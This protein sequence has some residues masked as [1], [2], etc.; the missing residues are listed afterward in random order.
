M[1]VGI[2]STA[3][4]LIS[5]GGRFI[6]D[7]LHEKLVEHG[8][9]AE[10][11]YLP[12]VEYQDQILSQSAA[13]RMMELDAYFDRVITIRPPA[14]TVRH[15]CKVVWFIHH[16]RGYYDLWD[17]PYSAVVH[18]AGGEALRAAIMAMDNQCLSEAHRIFTNSR[19][20]GDRLRR[21]NGM[22]SEVLYPPVLRPEMFVGGEHGDE[23]VAIC[24]VEHH[25][26]QHLMIEAMAHAR[27]P[28]RLRLCGLS[29]NPDYPRS[30]RDMATRLGV[31][32]RVTFEERWITEEEKAARLHSA[33]ASAYLPYDEDSYGYPTIEAAH[34]SRC[35]ITVADSG[36]VAEFVV[37]GENGLLTAPNPAELGA[38]FD[39]LWQDRAL[40]ARLGAAARER[41]AALGIDW[42]AAIERLLA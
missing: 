16:L 24:R 18:N 6:V 27:S 5:G 19:V 30:L 29:G 20:V 11:I 42:G 10:T 17:T 35:T 3:V 39:R 7:W 34:A 41:V 25:K 12:F 14:H 2:I 38:A 1:R 9:E 32:D 31:A 22:E 37:D 4:P 28:V 13:F 26:R 15:R 36:G 8:H 33:L 23:I 40:A 21:F